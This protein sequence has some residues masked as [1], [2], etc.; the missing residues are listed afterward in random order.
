[1]LINSRFIQNSIKQWYSS[2]KSMKYVS[3]MVPA[4][5]DTIITCSLEK[6]RFFLIT[7]TSSFIEIQHLKTEIYKELYDIIV[8]NIGSGV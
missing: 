3:E 1:M 4:L 7:G 6:R 5:V 2:Q 8:D